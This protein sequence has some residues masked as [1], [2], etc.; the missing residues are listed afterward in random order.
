MHTH[1]QNLYVFSLHD[2][3][4]PLYL[5]CLLLVFAYNLHDGFNFVVAISFA[6]GII[7]Y[8]DSKGD[9]WIILQYCHIGLRQDDI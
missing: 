5:I 1:S 6:G 9:L 8:Y 7:Y 2:Q 3:I 4:F